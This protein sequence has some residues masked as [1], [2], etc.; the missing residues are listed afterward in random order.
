[1]SS[2]A[3]D[4]CQ[5]QSNTGRITRR[6]SDRVID[7]LGDAFLTF[8]IEIREVGRGKI[9]A[10]LVAGGLLLALAPDTLDGCLCILT[11]LRVLRMGALDDMDAV[12]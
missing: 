1:M 11:N 5:R 10:L 8:F 3:S 7:L 4:T 6:D 9:F 12:L 2:G